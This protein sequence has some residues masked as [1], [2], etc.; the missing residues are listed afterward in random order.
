MDPINESMERLWPEAMRLNLLDDSLSS[1][2][3][4]RGSIDASMRERFLALG[5]YA[6][7]PKIIYAKGER[8]MG[9]HPA[10]PWAIVLRGM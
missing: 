10:K 8:C 6:E 9:L 5:R 3:A 7:F 2:L 4:S 1:D